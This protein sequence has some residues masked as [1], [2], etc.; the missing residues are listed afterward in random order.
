MIQFLKN[1]LNLVLFFLFDTRQR[2]VSVCNL[3]SWPYV[4]STSKI[5]S[6]F[7]LHTHIYM[8]ILKFQELNQD[9]KSE[10]NMF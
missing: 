6:A 7:L 1:I 8:N 10:L 3:N 5:N 2:L 9:Q 4:G